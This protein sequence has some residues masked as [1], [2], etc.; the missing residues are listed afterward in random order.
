MVRISDSAVSCV[1]GTTLDL[2]VA[3]LPVRVALR[4]GRS[5]P[6]GKG[7]KPSRSLT[8]KPTSS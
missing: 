8:A 7:A 2:C 4:I 1:S 6:S 3:E 5:E